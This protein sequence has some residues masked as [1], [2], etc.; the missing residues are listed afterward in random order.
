MTEPV[1]I[2]NF[3]RQF[4]TI[5]DSSMVDELK[6]CEAK[7][8]MSYIDEW[9]GK[10]LSVH[11][12]AG[13]AFAAGLERTRKAFYVEGLSEDSAIAQGLGALVAHYGDFE[14]PSDSAK[15]CERMCGAFEFY[16][17][18]YPLTDTQNEPITL[19]G[20]KRA[21]E[22]S[23]A[24]PLPITHPESGDPLIY[25][26]RM[27]A[28]NAYA[29]GSY[30][31]DEKTT[32]QLGATWSRQWDLRAQFTGYIWAC[33]KA[34]IKVDGAI[35]RGVSILKTKYE[36][37][38][39]ITYR[40]EWQVDRWYG[41]LLLWLERAKAAWASGTWLHNLGHTCAEYGGC[42]FRQVCTSQDPQPWLETYFERRHWNPLLRTEVKL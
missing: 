22:F 34:G 9:K 27:D 37:Q 2:T 21:I 19:P 8:N 31:T 6:S 14:C 30:I 42:A 18:N 35:I 20:G 26:G 4:P 41:E 5:W 40:P 16:W 39:A 29:G 7:C 32:T 11:L 36:T 23:F 10:G 1:P 25:C 28:I 13:A 24:E 3:T 15:S 12:H 38:Q 17:S 33:E